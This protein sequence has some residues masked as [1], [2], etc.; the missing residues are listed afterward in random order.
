MSAPRR[1][2]ALHR[3]EDL[4]FGGVLAWY[5]AKSIDRASDAGARLGEQIGPRLSAHRTALRNL[6]L[7][8]PGWG[9][10]QRQETARAMW[11]QLGRTLAEFAHMDRIAAYDEDGR[12]R[13]E[14]AE[15]L[16]AVK[17]AGRG[18]V[19]I[20]GHFANWEVMAAA[21]VQRGLTCH[22]TYRP[23]NNPLVDARISAVRRSYGVKLQS[24][25]GREGGLGLLRA[26]AKGETVALMNDQ[27]YAE[28]VAA[29]LFG[30]EAMTADGATRL[31]LRFGA[32]LIP[33][34]VRRLEGVRFEVVVHPEIPLL[35]DAPIDQAV[36]DAVGRI[37]AFVEARVRDAPEQWFW[38]HRRWPKEAWAAAGLTGPKAQ[39]APSSA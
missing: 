35:R 24:A 31:A 16:D 3:L 5:R 27:K 17:A 14:G 2:T 29:P 34:H 25:K 26:L 38:V 32:P 33:L 4:A 6:A 39:A 22:V 7:A 18:A 20:S 37:N 30:H 8:F 28:G 15:R 23:A 1:I 21:I 12:V 13:V 10:A 36:Q 11:R 9:D 19:F